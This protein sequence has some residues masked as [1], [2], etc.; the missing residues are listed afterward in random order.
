M[1]IL[2]NPRGSFFLSFFL[3]CSALGSDADHKV[4]LTS[5]TAPAAFSPAVGPAVLTGVISFQPLGPD[6]DN[7]AERQQSVV[8]LTVTIADAAGAIVA[9]LAAQAPASRDPRTPNLHTVAL[10]VNWDGR[11]ANGA[12]VADGTYTWRACSAMLMLHY[13]KKAPTAAPTERVMF[14]GNCM[15]GAILLD[16]VPPAI[17]AL[18]PPDGITVPETRP[19]ISAAI[20][21]FGSGVNWSSLFVTLDEAAIEVTFTDGGFCYTPRADL[22]QGEHCVEVSVTDVAGNT[23]TTSWHFT[24]AAQGP[25]IHNLQ[26]APESIVDTREPGISASFADTGGGVDVASLSINA[27]FA[28]YIFWADTTELQATANEDLEPGTYTVSVTVADFAGNGTTVTWS[29]TVPDDAPLGGFVFGGPLLEGEIPAGGVFPGS[30][31]IPETVNADS[32]SALASAAADPEGGLQKL[33]ADDEFPPVGPYPYGNVQ[34][35]FREMSFE[36][37]IAITDDKGVA[38]ATPQWLDNDV[39]TDWPKPGGHNWPVACA[40]GKRIK[41]TATIQTPLLGQTIQIKAEGPSLDNT[42]QVPFRIAP[43]EVTPIWVPGADAQATFTVAAENACPAQLVRYFPEFKIEWYYK[44]GAVFVPF[45][46]TVHRIYVTH[47]TQPAARPCSVPWRTL[48]ARM[49]SGKRTRPRS[50]MPF[51]RYSRHGK[52]KST[53]TSPPTA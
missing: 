36:D 43:F 41:I 31:S 40:A 8:R 48:A 15:S 16:S 46:R 17:S 49:R 23:A 53:T 10:S 50:L 39:Y 20:F 13:N 47:V 52:Y 30:D 33:D 22:L 9:T 14:A 32:I 18:T 5:L 51:T 28:L 26:P 45:T 11:D 2:L 21:D 42:G 7:T 25:T 3:A 24:V 34:V 44:S 35:A 12:P 19:L 27:P 1:F 37:T 6:V 4:T 29:F 38:Y